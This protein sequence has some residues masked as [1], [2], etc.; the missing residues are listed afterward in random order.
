MSKNLGVCWFENCRAIGQLRQLPYPPLGSDP[1]APSLIEVC[2][3]HW[4]EVRAKIGDRAQWRA[5]VRDGSLSFDAVGGR[6]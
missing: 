3:A 6:S 4:P 2:G 1:R 5:L